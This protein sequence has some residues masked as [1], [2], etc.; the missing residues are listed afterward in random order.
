MTKK[1][2][3]FPRGQRNKGQGAFKETKVLDYRS[4]MMDPLVISAPLAA[5][6]EFLF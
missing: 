5:V 3:N 1:R 6:D 2:E 4:I